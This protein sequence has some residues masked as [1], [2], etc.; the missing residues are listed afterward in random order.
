MRRPEFIA[1]Q[2]GNARGIL[3]KLIA[4]I[5]ARET[6]AD[7]AKALELLEIRDG[8]RV[9]DVGCGPGA[10]LEL[11]AKRYPAARTVGIDPSTAMVQVAT[12]RNR[13][14]IADGQVRILELPIEGVPD[15]VGPFDKALCSHVIY[16]WR[17][18]EAGLRAVGRLLV[19]GGKLSLLCNLKGGARTASFP[20][21]IYTFY[22][23]AELTA[24]LKHAGFRLVSINELQK[25]GPL[26]LLAEK[27]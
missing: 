12:R 22:E 20:D 4:H 15:D 10:M 11:I 19:D 14:A 9:V 25:D 17:D 16:F 23:C 26:V 18:L 8:D 2:S 5:M 27:V 7:N 6:F 24:A 1:S 3:G 13:K 21:S